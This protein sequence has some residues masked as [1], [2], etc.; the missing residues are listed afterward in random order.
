MKFDKNVFKK[1]C[2][3]H[4]ALLFCGLFLANS[5]IVAQVLLP[6]YTN[7]SSQKSSNS[8]EMRRNEQEFAEFLL[9]L[10]HKDNAQHEEG[11]IGKWIVKAE[12]EHRLEQVYALAEK[13]LYHPNSPY[14]NEEWYLLFLQY[15]DEHQ[16]EVYV[17][18]PRYQKHYA[19]LRKNRVGHVA[20]DF[21]FTTKAGEK[22]R[23]YDLGSEYIVLF[24][25]DP[26]CEECRYVKQRLESNNAFSIK[27]DVLVV[28]VYID[29]EVESWRK[30]QYPSTWLS[31]YAPEIDKKDLYDVRALPTLYLL[32]GQKNVLIKDE[33]IEKLIIKLQ[34]NS[35]L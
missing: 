3:L 18:N 13:Y 24:F 19:M 14:R 21:A 1:F 32:D 23:L 22:G 8:D 12:K 9:L 4:I 34:K 30:A 11:L 35:Y 25:H 27:R 10:K 29:D 15:A 26:N 5:P 7:H 6:E 2:F 17:K 28:A 16:L 33:P 31:V 20:T